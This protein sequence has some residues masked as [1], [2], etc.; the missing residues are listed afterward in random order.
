MTTKARKTPRRIVWPTRY[1]AYRHKYG[2]GAAFWRGIVLSE[3]VFHG[4]NI[5]SVYNDDLELME[6][7]I[8]IKLVGVELHL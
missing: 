7:L 4:Y 5:K 3:L 8:S 1:R 2:R 6:Y